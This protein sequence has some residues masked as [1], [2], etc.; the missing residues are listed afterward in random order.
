[1]TPPAAFQGRHL[2][3]PLTRR[4]GDVL[5][6]IAR[7]VDHEEIAKL[8]GVRITTVQNHIEAILKAFRARSVD[9]AV[10]AAAREGI[11]RS[12]RAGKE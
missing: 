9:D 12:Q 7:G 4:E 2:R 5:Q 11:V 1:M 10:A 6:L 8:L 3:R